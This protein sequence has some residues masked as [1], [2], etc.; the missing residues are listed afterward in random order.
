MR[1]IKSIFPDFVFFRWNDGMEAHQ[2][3]RRAV[4][5][6]LL[7]GGAV[8]LYGLVLTIGAKPILHLLYAGKYDEHSLLV[9]LFG[10][11]TAASTGAGI[12]ILA[13]KGYGRA[14]VASGIW[15]LSAVL[16]SLSS[17]PAMKFAGLEGAIFSATLAYFVACCMAYARLTRESCSKGR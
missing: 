4:H 12:F 13:L 3:Q 16:V 5:F 9:A 15:T 17:I 10:L 1:E 6:A 7:F 2:L 11:S 14:D 8:A